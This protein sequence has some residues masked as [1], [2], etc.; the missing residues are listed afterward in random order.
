MRFGIS[1]LALKFLPCFYSWV[2]LSKLKNFS[3]LALTYSCNMPN[4]DSKAYTWY[5]LIYMTFQRRQNYRD[6]ETVVFKGQG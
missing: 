5:Y 6:R 4:T 3:E 1:G 2:T